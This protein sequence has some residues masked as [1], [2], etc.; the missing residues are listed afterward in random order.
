MAML[1]MAGMNIPDLTTKCLQ[2][3]KLMAEHILIT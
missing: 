1:Y 2:V 3:G